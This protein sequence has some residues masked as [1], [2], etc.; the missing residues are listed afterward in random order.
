MQSQEI[1]YLEH[2]PCNFYL[3]LKGSPQNSLLFS[4]FIYFLISTFQRYTILCLLEINRVGY[5]LYNVTNL[6]Y[7]SLLLTRPAPAY[8]SA[9][10]HSCFFE[11]SLFNFLISLF[12]MTQDSRSK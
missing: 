10:T 4:F 3:H 2:K 8:R 7:N 9:F 6:T 12:H 5:S 1:Y 11:A